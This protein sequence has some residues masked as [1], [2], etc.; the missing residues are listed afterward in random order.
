MHIQ[1]LEKSNSV[2]I[3][4]NNERYEVML[5]SILPWEN[6]QEGGVWRGNDNANEYL[7]LSIIK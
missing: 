4:F 6:W 5:Y 2:N 3:N 1:F 7:Y